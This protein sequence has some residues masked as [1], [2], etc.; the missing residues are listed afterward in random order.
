MLLIINIYL[1]IYL[2]KQWYI[3]EDYSMS[4]S[5]KELHLFKCLNKILF[6]HYKCINVTLDHFNMSSLNKINSFFIKKINKNNKSILL[7]P[8]I[9]TI[10]YMISFSKPYTRV[11]QETASL[12]WIPAEQISLWLS[13]C[14]HEGLCTRHIPHRNPLCI[15]AAA[16]SL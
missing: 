2:W 5:S 4:K 1:F 6:K 12:S 10:V 16:Q 11:S 15:S 7:T 14:A 13:L 9:W 3:F 8:N